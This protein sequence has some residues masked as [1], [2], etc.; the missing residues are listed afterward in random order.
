MRIIVSYAYIIVKNI[1]AILMIV[2]VFLVAIMSRLFRKPIDVGLGPEPL[3]NNVYFKKS[4]INAGYSAETYVTHTYYIT[5]EFD[6]IFDKEIMPFLFRHFF[7]Q[8]YIFFFTLFRYKSLYI[9]YNGTVL[10]KCG[11]IW[12]YFDV[13]VYKLA[14]IKIVVMP[15]GSDA[16]Q[17]EYCNSLYYKYL[18]HKDYPDTTTIKYQKKV[19]KNVQKWTIHADCIIGGGDMIYYVPYCGDVI[20]MNFIS[21]DQEEYSEIGI[22]HVNENEPLRIAHVVNHRAIKGSVF[23]EKAISELQADGLN[24]EFINLFQVPGDEAIEAYKNADLVADQLVL[25]IFGMTAI[26]SMSFGKPVL[27]YVDEKII[28]T[29][30]MAGVLEPDVLPLINC[31]IYNVKEKIRELYFDREKLKDIGHKSRQYVEKYHSIEA[32]AALFKEVNNI[33]ELKPSLLG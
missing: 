6:Y 12:K 20:R 31:N 29:M 27:C 14:G 28:D 26:Q 33:I 5:Q 16:Y 3:I 19:K 24:I 23:F 17:L 1:I 21:I 22:I 30:V 10:E 2:P 18:M 11:V 13:Y 15:Y 7:R 25:G 32:G 4:L 9:Y 8:Y